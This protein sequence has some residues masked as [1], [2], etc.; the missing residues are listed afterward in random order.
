M[1]TEREFCS[2]LYLNINIIYMKYKGK[3]M[4]I[5]NFIKKFILN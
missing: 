1:K 2:Y 5:N 3:I 4:F